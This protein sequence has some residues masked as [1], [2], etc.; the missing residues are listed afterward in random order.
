MKQTFPYLIT[1]VSHRT[2]QQVPILPFNQLTNIFSVPTTVY[3]EIIVSGRNAEVCNGDE[4]TNPPSNNYSYIPL[5]NVNIGSEFKYI[6]VISGIVQNGETGVTSASKYDKIKVEAYDNG[7]VKARVKNGRF[8]TV[9]L[10]R[11]WFEEMRGLEEKAKERERHMKREDEAMRGRMR[12]L[13]P[14][15]ERR[16]EGEL[17]NPGRALEL[18]FLE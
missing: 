2:P 11:S 18:D 15:R 3:G 6:K 4:T 17:I 9:E 14:K 5:R 12:E 10:Q 13:I 16:R 8:E 7:D 1:K